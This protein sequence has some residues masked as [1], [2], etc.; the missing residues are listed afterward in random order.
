M[1]FVKCNLGTKCCYT[2][3]LIVLPWNTYILVTESRKFMQGT[4]MWCLNDK[5]MKGTMMWCL[6][7]MEYWKLKSSR[8]HSMNHRFLGSNKGFYTFTVVVQSMQPPNGEPYKRVKI[9]NVQ[10]MLRHSRGAFRKMFV[11]AD[12]NICILCFFWEMI[13]FLLHEYRLGLANI[14]VR[15]Q[16]SCHLEKLPMFVKIKIY[17][18]SLYLFIHMGDDEFHELQQGM[19]HEEHIWEAQNLCFSWF[20]RANGIS[21]LKMNVRSLK[22]P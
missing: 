17:R 14:C 20:G 3:K 18:P 22:N 9:Q 8:F 21:I 2:W 1:A 5:F 16:V 7:D 12:V 15:Y 13:S 10:T 4:M 19:L 11:I 6:N